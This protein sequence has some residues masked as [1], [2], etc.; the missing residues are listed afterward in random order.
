MAESKQHQDSG[1]LYFAYGSNLSTTQMKQRCPRSTPLGLAHLPGWMWMIN[2]RG[3]ANIVQNT[4]EISE[5]NFQEEEQNIGTEQLPATDGIAADQAEAD[6]GLGH[7][8]SWDEELEI[9]PGPG[10]YGLVYSLHPFDEPILDAYEGVPFAYE[11]E[12]LE[13]EWANSSSSIPFQSSSSTITTNTTINTLSDNVPMTPT[14]TEGTKETQPDGETT[15]EA[16]RNT[17]QVLVYIDFN[18]IT[19]SAPKEEY[20]GR[21]NVGIEEVMVKWNLPV[22]YVDDVL[23]PFIRP[24]LSTTPTP[25]HL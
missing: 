11:R 4:H 8:N 1:L 9:A 14:G 22:A 7:K 15:S 5:P 16:T 3:Y 25:H 2:E 18:R 6:E 17:I 21:M 12:M 23:R 13:A 20:V 24:S 10:V 19:P